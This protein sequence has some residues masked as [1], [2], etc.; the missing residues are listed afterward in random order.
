MKI[1]ES[2]ERAIETGNETEL[3]DICKNLHPADAAAAFTALNEDQQELFA[4][5]LDNEAL[6]LITSFLTSSPG[7]IRGLPC[8]FTVYQVLFE[9]YQV[10]FT[11]YQG[12]FEVY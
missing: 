1:P 11:V 8:S 6:S 5:Y 4:K 3:K 7:F 10:L 2:I 9:D 12:L